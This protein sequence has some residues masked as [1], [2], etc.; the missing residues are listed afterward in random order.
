MA[1]FLAYASVAFSA[2]PQVTISAKWPVLN[3][4][5]KECGGLSEDSRILRINDNGKEITHRFCT[6][7]GKADATIIKDSKGN[8]FLFL[9][10]SQGRGTNATS[11]Y[12][13]VYRVEENLVEYVRIP[14][15]EGAGPAS[16]WYYDYK[17]EKPKQGGL[18]ISLSLRIEGSDAKAYPK[19]K[20]RTIQIK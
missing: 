5:T 13:S 7:Y 6:S 19:E 17:I 9:T 12:L 15:S 2:E 3:P 10:F 14:I 4:D 1:L 16:R 18:T 11:D 20:K 8:N